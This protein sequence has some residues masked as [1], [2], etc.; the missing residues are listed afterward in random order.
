MKVL[1]ISHMYPSAP[2]PVYGIF[3]HKQVKA[4]IEQGLEVKVISPVP[5]AP[6]PLGVL[7][8]RWRDYAS[9][10]HKDKIEGVEVFYRRYPEFPRSFMLEHSGFFM[11]LGIRGLVREIFRTYKFD[12]IHAHVALPDGSA[13]FLLKKDFEVP[14]VVTVHG[15]DFQ[16][17][18]HRG[19]KQRLKVYE[20]LEGSDRI[21]T[22][23]TKLKNIVGDE[24]FAGKISVISNGTDLIDCSAAND[25]TSDVK[26]IISVSNLKKSKGIDLNIRALARLVKRYP[27]VRYHIVGDGE[28]RA[29]LQSLVDELNLKEHIVFHG[30]LSHAETMR[31][32]ASSDIFCLPSWQE[33]FGAVY[34][35]AMSQGIP[36]VGV[37]GEGIEDVIISGQNGLLVRP[38]NIDDIVEA[39]VSLLDDPGYA[40]TLAE[41]GRETVIN[42][43][44]WTRNARKTKELYS[45]L[46]NRGKQS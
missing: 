1:V 37:R 38:Q 39:L 31:Q 11:Y 10:P 17:T 29:N 18:I 6:W 46:E 3:V 9:I 4:L 16:S 13:A 28:E 8:K 35:E 5:Y 14:V 36:A 19:E 32:M 30:K 26:R 45:E 41:A 25:Y 24:S 33:G 12:L 23:S 15:Q 27:Q 44:T 42:G 2:K 22:V 20:V 21:I 43:Y 34:I 40:R 7:K